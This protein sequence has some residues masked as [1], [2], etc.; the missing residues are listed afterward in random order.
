[1]L[2]PIV[3]P[4]RR[5]FLA[6]GRKSCF[7]SF[8]WMNGTRH[9]RDAGP[10]F[11][12][13]SSRPIP[14]SKSTKPI[15]PSR[16]RR[17]IPCAFR[18]PIPSTTDDPRCPKKNRPLGNDGA[19]RTFAGAGITGITGGRGTDI[20]AFTT[21]VNFDP[22]KVWCAGF[23]MKYP[24]GSTTKP[25]GTALPAGAQGLV[26]SATEPNSRQMAPFKEGDFITYSGTLLV[27]PERPDRQIESIGY[28]LC[29]HYRSQRRPSSLHQV[30][31]PSTSR[32]ANSA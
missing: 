21:S 15:R 17:V 7:G 31:C 8:R 14:A 13:S 2:E 26:A 32:S 1:M 16:R 30:R 18:A 28:H 27:G 29:S 3:P 4:R 10:R 22:G 24:P 11:A 12:T 19:C 6:H 9:L 25:D 20:M 5:P 23:V